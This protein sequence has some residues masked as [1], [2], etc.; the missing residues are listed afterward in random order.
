M[1]VIYRIVVWVYGMLISFAALFNSKAEK[2]VRGRD[3]W[4]EHL[5][6]A[7]SGKPAKR[8]WFHCSS[9]GE[10]EQGRPVL[11]Q[12]RAEYPGYFIVLS[13]FSP[14]GYEV[15]KNEK[16]VDYV[17]YLP[18]DSRKNSKDFIR[19]LKPSLVF[20]VKYDFWYYY[21]KELHAGKIPF[22]CISAI[23]RPG[24]VFFKPYG[25]FF[26]KILTRYSHLFVQDQASLELLYK[27][28]IPSVTVSGDTRFDRVIENSILA[29]ELPLLQE[30]CQDKLSIVAGSTW[31]KD[32]KIL[33]EL[34]EKDASIRL[35]IAPHETGEA[36]LKGIEN[37]FRGKTIRF[38][39]AGNTIPPGVNVIIIDSIGIL[40]LLYRFGKYSYVGGGFGKG[41]HNILEAAVYGPP[42]FF[43]PEYKKFKEARDLKALGGVMSI[44]NMADM[45]AHI[46]K[47]ES[48]DQNYILISA[49]NKKYIEDRK[50]ATQILMNFLRL[51]Y[52]VEQ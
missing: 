51:N 46:R 36:R 8:I 9:L 45:Y 24:Q 23:F 44:R 47:L 16:L 27:N 29:A 6:Q 42:V 31:P 28:R 40:S 32:E 37:R 19:L 26:R 21:G 25:K 48:D 5:E 14:S 18:L 52:P 1:E 3:R 39:K 43:G 15:R 2:W 34:T 4:R 41:I 35:I 30:F 22:F 20:F 17:C 7:L 12:I 13:F 50:G 10:F 33:A 38:S 11:E 49:R